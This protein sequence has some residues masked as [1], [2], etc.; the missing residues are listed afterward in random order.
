MDKVQIT[1][2]SNTDENSFVKLSNFFTIMNK[3]FIANKQTLNF[4]PASFIKFV[5]S[6]KPI[7]DFNIYVTMLHQQ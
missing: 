6:N 1:D 3:W 2:P 4:D 7:T 5:T